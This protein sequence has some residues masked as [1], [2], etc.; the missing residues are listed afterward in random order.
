MYQV[1]MFL[2]IGWNNNSIHLVPVLILGIFK[3]PFYVSVEVPDSVLAVGISLCTHNNFTG[4]VC[5]TVDLAAHTMGTYSIAI[6][7]VNTEEVVLITCYPAMTATIT[8]GFL[9]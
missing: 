3:F 5:T 2:D 6:V 9:W 1:H 8:N 4:R 7:K